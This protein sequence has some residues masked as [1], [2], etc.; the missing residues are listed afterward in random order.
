MLD[1]LGK[2]AITEGGPSAGY[3]KFANGLL[4]QWGKNVATSI[5]G[6]LVAFT[7]PLP[8][9]D[10]P[11]IVSMNQSYNAQWCFSFFGV[12]DLT[13]TGLKYG[14]GGNFEA[15]GSSALCWLAIG[16]WK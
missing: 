9:L 16:A 12:N 2:S 15:D 3:Q 6:S 10:V 4:I 8:F 14:S 7:F 11:V 1:Y 13:T 5:N